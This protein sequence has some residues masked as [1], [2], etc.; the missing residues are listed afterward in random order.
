MRRTGRRRRNPYSSFN[1]RTSCEVRRTYPQLEALISR[2]QLTHLLRGATCAYVNLDGYIKFQLTH[3]LRGA[4]STLANPLHRILRFN[5]RTSCEVR[6]RCKANPRVPLQFQLT[7]LLRG[8]THL[9]QRPRLLIV[10][11]THAPLARCDQNGELVNLA[12]L[13]STHA[14]LARCDKRR[15][16]N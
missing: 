12:P 16:V 6:H 8:A 7:H 14:P 2:F 1:S 4:T 10:V 9:V 3:L 13:V 11:S 15:L 5:S